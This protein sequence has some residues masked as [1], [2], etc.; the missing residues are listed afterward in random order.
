MRFAGKRFLEPNPLPGGEEGTAEGWDVGDADYF[1]A[2]VRE[3]DGGEGGDEDAAV[4][5]AGGFCY[6][7]L[8]LGYRTDFAAQADLAGEADVGGDRVVYVGGEYCAHYGEVAGRFRDFQASCHVQEH[9]LDA[10]LETGA[11]LQ[12]SEKHVQTARVE[13]CRGTLG[14]AVGCGAHKRLNLDEERSRAVEYCSYRYAAEI[15]RVHRNQEFGR[16]RDF[17]QTGAGHLEY[18]DFRG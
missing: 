4:F 10:Q 9:V 6:A 13:T 5:E 1:Y 15:L 8:N 17:D 16:I 11:F 12:D 3:V 2:G 14:S 7:A 18:S